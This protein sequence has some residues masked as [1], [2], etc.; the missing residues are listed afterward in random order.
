[1]LAI[2]FH[3]TISLHTFSTDAIS[4]GGRNKCARVCFISMHCN[5]L[6]MIHDPTMKDI[7]ICANTDEKCQDALTRSCVIILNISYLL[8][9]V[10]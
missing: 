9:N 3:T 6:T 10:M 7:I 5:G 8:V 4:A 2:N 1:M